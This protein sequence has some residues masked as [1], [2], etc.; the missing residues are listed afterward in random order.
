[1]KKPAKK[2][3]VVGTGYWG[4]N[5]VRNFASLGSLSVLCDLDEKNLN[6]SKKTYPRLKTTASLPDILSDD[7]IDAVVISTP[8]E[9][10]YQM[11]RD[12]LLADKHVFVEKPLALNVEQGEELVNLSDER[13]RILMVGHLL[14]YHPAVIKLKEL[15]EGGELGKI[16]YIYSNRLN[17]GKIRREENILWSFA[18]HDISVI[19]SLTGEMPDSAC[20]LGGNYLHEKIADVTL[21][22]LSF[23]SGIKAHIFVS[24]LHPYKEQRLVIVGDRKMASFNDLNLEDKLI[25]YPHIIEWKDHLPTPNMK[26]GQVVPVDQVEPLRE[27]CRHFLECITNNSQP[28]TGGPE[29][30]KVLTVL[31]ACQES[32][33]RKGKIVPVSPPS[34]RKKREAQPYFVDKTS[35]VDEGCIIG[36]GTRIWHFSHIIKGSI[37]GR[38]C[39]IGQ[40]V[41]IGPDVTIGNTVKIQNN[42][43]VYPGVTLED[44]VFCG[45]SMVFTN[46]FNPR[47]YIPRKD[48]IRPTTVKEG[49]TLGA[50]ST[51]I[52]GHT[53]GR[54]A[55]VAA[56]SVVLHDIPDFAL[57]AGNP[58][59]IKGWICRCGVRLHFEDGKAI[60][61]ACGLKYRREKDRVTT[62]S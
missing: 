32:L 40:N 57:V 55:F 39:S 49:A 41:M 24:W 19:L 7:R 11:V 35:T 28:R 10:H 61:D 45:P 9:M 15:V 51:I 48:E 36:R 25:V 14:Q 59:V 33:E 52:C 62:I 1:M 21:S 6:E 37:V 3:A 4:K 43:S 34:D 29:G 31:Q 23:P 60:C 26:D 18:P 56:G 38:D 2:I 12:C 42:V 53:I 27:E 30:L 47:S 22:H 20:S 5:L 58:A 46:V 17:L 13:E 50:N 54:F 44:G 8:A 16:Q